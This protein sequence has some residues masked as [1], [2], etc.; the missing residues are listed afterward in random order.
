M[1]KK[2]IAILTKNIITIPVRKIITVLTIL[3]PVAF[4]IF[5]LLLRVAFQ[6]LPDMSDIVPAGTAGIIVLFIFF[7]ARGLDES[8]NT[9]ASLK[10]VENKKKKAEILD[11][12]DTVKQLIIKKTAQARYSQ[13][14]L[15]Y[16]PKP[17]ADRL[18]KFGTP[19]LV[20]S[21]VCPIL[22]AACYYLTEP[23]PSKTVQSISNLKNSIGELPKE[24]NVT[25]SR[26]WHILAGGI[27]FGFLCL[28]AARGLLAQQANE[29]KTYVELGQ[30][31]RYFERLNSIVELLLK[32][33]ENATEPEKEAIR[34]LRDRLLADPVT[35]VEEETKKTED[36]IQSKLVSELAKAMQSAKT[37][38]E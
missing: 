30:K 8:P 38:M 34:F 4:L 6:K 28:A 16:Q 15:I 2:I 26:D 1:K 29:M 37:T 5:A 20:A 25:V 22:S 10:E 9:R 21:L 7:I 13:E 31:V 12:N 18:Y 32:Q 14:V 24:F 17:K 11:K 33:D 27:A 3:A 36:D 19:L 23:L 35:A